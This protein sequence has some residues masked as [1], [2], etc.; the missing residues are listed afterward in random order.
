MWIRIREITL[1]AASAEQREE[2]REQ[3][4]RKTCQKL[5]IER[6]RIKDLRVYRKSPDL[7]KREKPLFVY[8]V[9]AE[10]SGRLPSAGAAQF[11]VIRRPEDGYAEY[12]GRL[13]ERVKPECR[14]A[15]P[16][17]AGFGPAGIFAALLLAEAGLSPIVVERGKQVEERIKDVALF[18]Q[19]NQLD[20][21]SNI[22]FG[23]GGAGTFSD[24]K[25]NSLIREKDTTGRFV[26]ETFVKFG[27]PEEILYRNKP[28]IGTDNLR[29]IV[30]NI[31]EYLI[32][33]GA[34]IRFETRL[35]GISDRECEGGR[36][37]SGA[38]LCGPQ[39]RCELETDCIILAIGHSARDTF[40][41]LKEREIAMERKAFSVGLRIE[42]LQSD[43]DAVQ[44]GASARLLRACWGPADY[45]LSHQTSN[46]RG[47]YTFCMC[48]GGVVVGAA[49]EQGGL[50]T[51][52]MS[53]YDRAGRNANSALLVSVFPEDFPGTDVLGGVAF[54]RR[55]ERGAFA[56][57]GGD[58]KA[59]CQLVG[60]FLAGRETTALGEI[61]PTFSNG[62]R[63]ADLREIL[64]D[65]IYESLKEGLTA[66]GKKLA[67]FDRPDA[68]LTGCETRSSSPVRI[69]RDDAGRSIS[70]AGLYPAGEGAGY[71]G[72]IL[73][74][75][76]DGIKA[77]EKWLETL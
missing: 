6:S 75:A 52:G 58:W 30:K 66:F 4:L 22:Q 40:A 65:A 37:V 71:A 5:R 18:R 70:M 13:R 16:V 23:E 77:V 27:A 59:P 2:E 69:L 72:G 48:P 60:D 7:R 55:L 46:G 29:K 26:L 15:R 3:L 49:S 32:G 39:G 74:A 19:Q 20:P 63:P 62:C 61:E 1:P 24:G 21:E 28:H 67:G 12:I 43:I 36:R 47:V 51:N 25:L 33:L 73:S 31:R 9:D 56:L 45:K 50:V 8:T 44:Y 35:D 38:L 57:G 64:P 76:A 14:A 41:W 68:V 17:V 10:L 42:H 11:T 34:E 54:Q 53:N